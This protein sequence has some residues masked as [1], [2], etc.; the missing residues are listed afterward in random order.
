MKNELSLLWSFFRNDVIINKRITSVLALK[1]FILMRICRYAISSLYKV[2][3]RV[4]FL[5]SR[6]TNLPGCYMSNK[7]DTLEYH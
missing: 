1:H 3:Y 4:T 2:D 6:R 5:F 7:S